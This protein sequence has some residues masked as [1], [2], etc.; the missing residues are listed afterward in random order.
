MS[1]YNIESKQSELFEKTGVFFAFSEKQ[2]REG[3]KE[4]C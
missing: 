3:K 4:G 2:L 1:T